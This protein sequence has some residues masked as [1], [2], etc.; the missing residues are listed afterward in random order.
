MPLLIYEDLT[1]ILVWVRPCMCVNNTLIEILR[2]DKQI[3]HAI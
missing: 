2:L 3:R 1:Q